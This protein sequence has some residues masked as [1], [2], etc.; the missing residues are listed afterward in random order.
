VTA[1]WIASAWSSAQSSSRRFVQWNQLPKVLLHNEAGRI[2]FG[3]SIKDEGLG[4]NQLPC[5]RARNVGSFDQLAAFAVANRRFLFVAAA[6]LARGAARRDLG[7]TILDTPADFRNG[8]PDTA[9]ALGVVCH[10][11]P[12]QSQV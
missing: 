10:C 8:C 7:V 1:A 9:V 3:D 12:L 5:T 2:S 11:S 6:S 4:G